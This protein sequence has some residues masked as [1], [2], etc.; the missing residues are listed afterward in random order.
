[1][2]NRTKILSVILPLLIISACEKEVKQPASG[3]SLGQIHVSP[4]AGSKSVS[5][6]TDGLWRVKSLDEW[7]T[8]DVNGREGSSA[9]TF[10][11]TSNESNVLGLKLTRKGCI[12]ITRL[13]KNIADTL[14]II[15]QGVPDGVIHQTDIISDYIETTSEEQIWQILYCNLHGMDYT[16]AET[17]LNSHDCEI[18]AA[19]WN[20]SDAQA[21]ASACQR[22][23]VTGN[24]VLICGCDENLTP[25]EDTCG[26]ISEFRKTWIQVA[27][28]REA[29]S[30]Q[31]QYSDIVSL[32]DEGYNTTGSSDRW[33]IGGSLYHYSS[34]EA[35]YKATPEWYPANSESTDFNADKYAWSNNLIDCV[36]MTSQNYTP[37]WSEGEKSW[38]ADYVYASATAWNSVVHVEVLES[39]EGMKHKPILVTLKY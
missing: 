32:L 10:S 16:T 12:T 39:A 13:D 21:F 34:V 29:S 4:A 5:V 26:I 2:K 8:L 36:W 35:G 31:K 11:Y 15:Q 38:R 18:K 28:F 1:M 25:P 6:N 17:W 19:I 7:I 30:P 27:D 23:C 22:P 14:Y 24:G 33:L 37:T 3:A 20:E 9:F